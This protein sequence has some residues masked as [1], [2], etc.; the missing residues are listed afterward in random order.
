MSDRIVLGLQPVREAIRAHGAAIE[1]VLIAKSDNPRIAAV[2]R[3]ARD[4]SI[5]VQEVPKAHIDKLSRGVHH[6]GVAA[7]APPLDLLDLAATELADDEL[8]VM[9]DKITDPHNFGAVIRGVVGLGG[10]GI[11]WG[12]HHAAP[13]SPATF[14]ASAGAVEHARLFQTPSLRGATQSLTERGVATVALDAEAGQTLDEL[15]LTGP[16]ALVIGSED[17][18]VTKGV[19]RACAARAKLPMSGRI[20]SLNASVASAIAVYEVRRQRRSVT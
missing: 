9:L 4:Q 12:Q 15:D 5:E 19:R 6:Q 13:L 7:F 14:R 1:R 18:G 20:G 10:T 2:G 11:V 17:R 3:F 8:L 16:V